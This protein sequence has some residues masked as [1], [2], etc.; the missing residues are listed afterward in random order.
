MSA[1]RKRDVRYRQVLPKLRSVLQ[2]QYRKSAEE[3]ESTSFH[4][5][6]RSGDPC[7]GRWI[8][9]LNALNGGASSSSSIEVSVSG[10]TLP[11]DGSEPATSSENAAESD[12]S[13]ETF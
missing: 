13:T 1:V 8:F 11:E 9:A 5:D 10:S 12:V 3:V 4:R 7:R 2:E 6:S